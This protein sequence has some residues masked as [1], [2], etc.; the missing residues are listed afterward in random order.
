MVLFY[1]K[2]GRNSLKFV[3]FG[4]KNG[5]YNMNMAKLCVDVVFCKFYNMKPLLVSGYVVALMADNI[6]GLLEAVDVVKAALERGKTMTSTGKFNRV[7]H[8]SLINHDSC[9]I[10]R[11]MEKRCNIKDAVYGFHVVY[12][13]EKTACLVLCRKKIK[14]PSFPLHSR[15]FPV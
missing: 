6:N 5:G 9:C 7:Q 12:F 15:G 11:Q 4:K 14:N 2:T 10:S 13:V 3:G 8:Q 1:H